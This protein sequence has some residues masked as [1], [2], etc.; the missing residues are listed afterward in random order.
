MSVRWASF[1]FLLILP[2]LAAEAF[3]Y[4]WMNPE[5]SGTRLNRPVFA[6]P[7]IDE[8]FESS[9]EQFDQVKGEL[10][11]TG[12]WIGRQGGGAVPLTQ[13]VWIEWDRAGTRNTLEAFRHLP[14]Q[15]MGSVGMKLEREFPQRSLGSG[16]QRLVFDSTL[17]RP[18]RG[19]PAMHVFKAVW[20][21]GR[22]GASLREN[23]L[24]TKSQNLFG[25]RLATA[26]HRFKP[27]QTRVLMAG[28]IGL[29]SEELAWKFF[30]R[31]ILRQIQWTTEPTQPAN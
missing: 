9:P 22:V 16:D 3:S 12:G 25:L 7:V 26:I 29:P 24:E 18:L 8:T 11:C 30:S 20:V 5:K 23:I 21:S 4:F 10:L 28:V 17:F 2:V 27:E 13:L 15:C 6:A 19:G 31:E 14:E 1:G